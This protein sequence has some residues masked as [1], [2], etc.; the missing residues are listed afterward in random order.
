MTKTE[1]EL[2]QLRKE[3]ADLRREQDLMCL[4]IEVM[5]VALE[6][7]LEQHGIPV[8]KSTGQTTQEKLGAIFQSL[9]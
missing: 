5:T 7:K 6:R 1:K 4:L 2:E 8:E 9:K 3:N